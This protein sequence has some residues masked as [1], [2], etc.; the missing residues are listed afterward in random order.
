MTDPTHEPRRFEPDGPALIREDALSRRWAARVPLTRAPD[1]MPMPYG[2]V[3][4]VAV[5]SV[6]GP[7][8]QRGASWW[9]GYD[10]V[11]D[12]IKAALSDPRARAVVLKLNSPGGVAAGCFEAVRAIRAAVQASGKTLV[13]Y[14][15]E[16]ACSGAYA[17][18]CAASKIYLPA[19]GEVGSIGVISSVVSMRRALEESGF[20]VRVVRS[21]AR[22]ALGHPA[23]PI[24]DEAVAREQADVDALA[25]QFF[26]LVSSARGLTTDAVSALEGDTRM[27][28]AAVAAGLADAV[29]TFDEAL[30]LT[31]SLPAATVAAP[32]TKGFSTMSE[33]L[34][35]AVLAL[36]G[37]TNEDEALGRL[38]AWKDT[39]ARVPGLELELTSLRATKAQD[40]REALLSQ[41]ERELRIT[42]AQASAARAGTGFL[43]SLSTPQLKAY[44]AESVPLA[45]PPVQQPAEIPNAATEVTL[46]AEEKRQAAS[47]GISEADMLATKKAHLGVA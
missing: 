1:G 25:G 21:G 12:R 11:T 34:T 19:S 31:R 23:D 33:K 4:D 27:G 32:T 30:S 3:G 5:V 6:D 40:E 7:L 20:D 45:K 37:T 2:L 10:S 9:D 8:Q 24:S 26:A 14:A 22:K 15:D 42:P 43:A 29:C 47:L 46:T 39:A 44:L 16:M 17:L 18:A 41:G 36:A 13:A 28:A 35:A 38:G